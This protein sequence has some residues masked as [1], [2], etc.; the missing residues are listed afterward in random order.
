MTTSAIEKP[1]VNIGTAANLFED[2]KDSL[3]KN[4]LDFG[5]CIFFV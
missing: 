1:T 3:S 5:K 4:G 2:L